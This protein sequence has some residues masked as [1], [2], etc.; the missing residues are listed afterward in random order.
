MKQVYP[1]ILTKAAGGYAAYVPDFDI[2]T[3]GDSL[4]HIIEMARDAIG[5][6][7]IDL[8]DEGKVVP[9]P[10]KPE[11]IQTK[12]GETLSLVDI[13]FDQYRR[14]NENRTVRRN[15]TLPSWLNEKADQAGLNVS[16]V[17]QKALKRELNLK[18]R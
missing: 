18:N 6:V 1:I 2:D 4:A 14:A 11:D 15:V 5:L 13:D 9:A 8:Q 3:Q 12:K 10:S 7:G 17:L 16:G